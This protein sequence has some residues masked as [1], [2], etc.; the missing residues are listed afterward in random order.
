MTTKQLQAKLDKLKMR[1]DARQTE[2]AG[3]KNQQKELKAQL[4]EAKAAAKAKAATK[5]RAT[6]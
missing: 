5:A 3:L 2:L 6:V 4:A 1:I